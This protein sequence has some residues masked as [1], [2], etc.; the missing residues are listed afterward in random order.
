MKNALLGEYVTVDKEIARGAPV[1]KGTRVS[2]SSLFDY[3]VDSTLEEFLEEFPSVSRLQ[4]EAVLE[5]KEK[6]QA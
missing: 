4:A 3:L 5:Y 1:F 6:T 2:V